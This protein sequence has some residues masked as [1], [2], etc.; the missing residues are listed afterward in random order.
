MADET[1][2]KIQ[3][4]PIEEYNLANN[5]KWIFNIPLARLFNI[6][7]GNIKNGYYLDY[8]LNCKNISFP[9][10]RLGTTNV[11]F[12]NYSFEVSTRSNV[13]TKEL[14]ITFTMSDNWLQY[15]MLLK[16]FELCDFTRYDQDRSD[17]VT[18]DLGDGVMNTI[19]KTDYEKYM[20]DSGANPYYSTQ[21]PVVTTNL[22]LMDNF[23]RRKC[24]FNFEGCWL[25]HI[26]NVDLDYS[27]TDGTD[28]TC[29]FSMAY[30]KYNVFNN[31]P[32]LKK[33]FP[34]GLY[35]DNHD[36]LLNELG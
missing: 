28:V 6:Q 35:N 36:A 19:A 26:R 11:T 31:D 5:T 1:T 12:L 14:N 9:E 32:E 7:Y 25:K 10:F 34:D 33:F 2:N 29:N 27:K 16:W 17:T 24:T 21:G 23:M 18:V 15:L 8:P 30:Y 4:L 13:S 3:D 22:Y 20:Y